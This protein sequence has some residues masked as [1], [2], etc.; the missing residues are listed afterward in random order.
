MDVAY[1]PMTAGDLESVL[2]LWGRTVG[3]GLNESDTPKQL[4]LYLDRNPNLSLVARDGARLVGEQCSAAM[5]DA[6]ATFIIWRWSRRIEGAAS[7]VKWSKLALP[8]F[9]RWGF[10]NATSS[11]MLTTN[12][13]SSFGGGAAGRSA[14]ISKSCSA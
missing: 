2:D 3:V 14:A 13:A 8:R 6:A 11:F 7:G 5:M 10:S 4:T 9:R 1:S 12:L